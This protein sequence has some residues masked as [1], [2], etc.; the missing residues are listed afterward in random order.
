MNKVIVAAINSLLFNSKKDGTCGV[1][2]IV[3]FVPIPQ[4][5]CLLNVYCCHFII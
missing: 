1:Y 2:S 4:V 5:D 3:A